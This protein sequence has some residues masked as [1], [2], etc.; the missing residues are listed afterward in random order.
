[1]VEK[2]SYKIGEIVIESSNH[3][4]STALES[5][6]RPFPPIHNGFG[7]WRYARGLG[8]TN[9]VALPSS[10]DSQGW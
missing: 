6:V 4:A 8:S 5:V 1:M 3:H 10:R 2:V 7:E 9:L